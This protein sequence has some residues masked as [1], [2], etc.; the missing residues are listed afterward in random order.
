L[1]DGCLPQISEEGSSEEASR[2]ARK[3]V[4]DVYYRSLPET[5]FSSGMS[6]ARVTNIQLSIGIRT[7]THNLLALRTSKRIYW[8][9]TPK[10]FS[11]TS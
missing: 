2:E 10:E 3:E 4:E 11:A 6:D 5:F 7:L 8:L 9:N 1:P